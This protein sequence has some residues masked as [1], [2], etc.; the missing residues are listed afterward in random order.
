MGILCV[1]GIINIYCEAVGINILENLA[2][3]GII[4][5]EFANC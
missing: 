2:L 4:V 1:V 5:M 3:L